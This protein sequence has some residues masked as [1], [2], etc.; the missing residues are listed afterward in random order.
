VD[1]EGVPRLAGA[2]AVDGAGGEIAKH[3]R[4]GNDDDADVAFGIDIGGEEP[5]AQ[6]EVVGEKLEND[7]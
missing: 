4:G 2:V 3:L 5:V 7:A 1:R 6:Q